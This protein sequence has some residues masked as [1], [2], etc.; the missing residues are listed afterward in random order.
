[1]IRWNGR[2]RGGKGHCRRPHM[3]QFAEK[4]FWPL[5]D[6]LQYI[7]LGEVNEMNSISVLIW[8]FKVHSWRNR[9]YSM[10]VTLAYPRSREFPRKRKLLSSRA[11]S[12]TITSLLF[13]SVFHLRKCMNC[14]TTGFSVCT[15]RIGVCGDYNIA[16]KFSVLEN[17]ISTTRF[18]RC[19]G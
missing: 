16:N 12:I 11:E 19:S 6:L 7:T 4:W 2:W 18:C 9:K 15:W 13:S 3:V 10:Y 8:E 5:L 14:K 17:L 1:M